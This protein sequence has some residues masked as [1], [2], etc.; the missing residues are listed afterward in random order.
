ML[1]CEVFDERL[2]KLNLENK[3]KET[4]FMELIDAVATVHPELD[5]EV[6]FTAI[7]TRE[8]KM[9]TSIVSGVA[10]PHG[11]YPGTGVVAGAIGISGSGIDY[12]ALDHKPVHCIFLIIMGETS[13]EKHVRVLSRILSLIQS[14]AFSYLRSANNPE[15]VHTLLSHFK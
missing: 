9:N 14:S 3:T 11:Y 6:M 7:K 8:S 10:V 4:A 13:R 2:I 1:L 15:E 12:D 5:R